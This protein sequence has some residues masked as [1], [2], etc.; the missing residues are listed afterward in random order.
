MDALARWQKQARTV[1]YFDEGYAGSQMWK[2][3]WEAADGDATAAPARGRWTCWNRCERHPVS[4]ASQK[5][6]GPHASAK[7]R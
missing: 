2:A 6:E 4:D 1:G 3:D 5:R 7:R